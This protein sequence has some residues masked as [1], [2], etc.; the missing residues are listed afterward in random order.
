M[1]KGRPVGQLVKINHVGPDE[2]QVSSFL[3]H[4][5]ESGKSCYRLDRDNMKKNFGAVWL[6]FLKCQLSLD[7]YKAGR[8]LLFRKTLAYIYI[9]IYTVKSGNVVTGG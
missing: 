8:Q 2:Q 9:Y 5:K 3:C 7:Q 6:Q 4:E 1:R